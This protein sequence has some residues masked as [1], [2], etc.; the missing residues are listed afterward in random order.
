MFYAFS[1]RV[2]HTLTRGGRQKGSSPS[3]DYY[4]GSVA[5]NPLG[6][7]C[8]KIWRKRISQ[9]IYE[10]MNQEDVCRTALAPPWLLNT[11]IVPCKN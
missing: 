3:A 9:L 7:G 1:K 5:T 2:V 6:E 4:N 8:L 11:E 10:L